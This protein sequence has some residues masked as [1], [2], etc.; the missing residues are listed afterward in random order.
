MKKYYERMMTAE[1]I[2]RKETEQELNQLYL[3]MEDIYNALWNLKD[4]MNLSKTEKNEDIIALQDAFQLYSFDFPYKVRSIFSLM[5]IGSYADAICV[6]RTIVEAEIYY[7]YFAKRNDGKGLKKYILQNEKHVIKLIN[8]FE[9]EVPGFYDSKDG[10]DF[11]CQSTH[12][13]PLMIAVLNKN[14]DSHGLLSHRMDKINQNGIK[15]IINY[16]LPFIYMHFENYK[17]IFKENTISN[18]NDLNKCIATIEDKIKKEIGER[19]L[20][21][22][23]NEVIKKQTDYYNILMNFD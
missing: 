16:L 11:M 10:Y 13:N 17:I 2:K 21:N 6:L 19:L 4:C 7:K 8:I 1:N 15:I 3:F 5:E 20:D 23:N 22:P 14:D 12:C 18:D 9:A